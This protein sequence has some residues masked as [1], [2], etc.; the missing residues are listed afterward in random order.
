MDELK[1]VP[2]LVP[3]VF[4]EME[5]CLSYLHRLKTVWQKTEN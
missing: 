2:F 4:Y 3:I 5:S 1:E